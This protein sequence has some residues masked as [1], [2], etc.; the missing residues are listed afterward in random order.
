[1]SL[2]IKWDSSDT[3]FISGPPGERYVHFP[4]EI[5]GDVNQSA[6]VN[7]VVTRQDT[8]VSIAERT[9]MGV[10]ITGGQ[11]IKFSPAL[12]VDDQHFAEPLT[13]RLLA[14]MW[15]DSG[16]T[17]ILT[18]DIQ[19][20]LAPPNGTSKNWKYVAVGLGAIY[21]LAKSKALRAR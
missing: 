15:N 6:N 5:T 10:P 9:F 17:P 20:T 8:G 4:M 14:V 19:N 13:F 1:M 7:V 16:T 12:L 18:K 3:T 2:S 21:I 11:W